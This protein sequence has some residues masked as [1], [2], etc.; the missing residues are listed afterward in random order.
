M[1]DCG[2][3]GIIDHLLRGLSE[4]PAMCHSRGC[5]VGSCGL[6]RV[7]GEWQTELARKEMST[8]DGGVCGITELATAKQKQSAAIEEPCGHVKSCLLWRSAM[9][10]LV[11]AKEVRQCRLT[12]GE[13][14][15]DPGGM[16][17]MWSSSPSRLGSRLLDRRG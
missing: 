5:Y 14:A 2:W 11:M 7:A 3:D 1:S 4:A 17:C 10:Q 13:F 15:G 12:R 9:S 6:A 16:L 8:I